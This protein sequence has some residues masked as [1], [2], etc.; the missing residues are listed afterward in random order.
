M[1]ISPVILLHHHIQRKLGFPKTIYVHTW[2]ICWGLPQVVYCNTPATP[3]PAPVTPGSSLGSLDW[4]HRPTLV[5]SAHFVL[6][7][8]HPG[9]TSRSV[10]HPQIAPSQAR[11]TSEFFSNELPEKKLQLVDMSIL[12][13]L[14][15]PEPGS[16]ILPPLEDRRPRR[17]TPSPGTSPLSTRLCVQCWHMLHM[18]AHLTRTRPSYRKGRL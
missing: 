2:Y 17:S 10:T 13:I 8:A 15:S 4:P 9:R 18:S 12:S 7:R 1:I 3:G 5:F 6:T 16:H 14:L 11:L